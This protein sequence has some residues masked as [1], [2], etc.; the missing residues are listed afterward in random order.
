M[1]DPRRGRKKAKRR[2]VEVGITFASGRGQ[3]IDG[4]GA[5][6]K[7]LSGVSVLEIA[8]EGLEDIEILPGSATLVIRRGYR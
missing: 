2:Y 7:Q 6:W 8:R 1:A 3:L 5:S 4:I